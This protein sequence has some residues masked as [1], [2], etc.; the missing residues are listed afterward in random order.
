MLLC[1]ESARAEEDEL[2]FHLEP[3]WALARTGED[4]RHGAGGELSASLGLSS[5]GWVHFSA[6]G[7][8]FFDGPTVFEALSGVVAALDV[9]RTIPFIEVLGGLEVVDGAV[10]PLVRLGVGA[11]YLITPEISM[12][13]ALRF[14]P[15]TGSELHRPISAGLRLSWRLEI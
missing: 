12:G 5:S 6:G 4:T 13:A 1:S 2:L 8:H 11:D 14:R 7:F 9:L 10:S 3:A 15:L